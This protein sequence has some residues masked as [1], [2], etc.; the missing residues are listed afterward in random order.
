MEASITVPAAFPLIDTKVEVE[1]TVEKQRLID[2][3]LNHDYS[4]NWTCDIEKDVNL[5]ILSIPHV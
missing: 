4:T 3:N 2:L 5:S 1:K